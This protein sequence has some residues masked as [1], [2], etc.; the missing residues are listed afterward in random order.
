MS[1]VV[2]AL[3]QELVFRHYT[4]TVIHYIRPTRDLAFHI[5]Q[6]FI[7]VLRAISRRQSAILQYTSIKGKGMHH[8]QI[9][10]PRMAKLSTIRLG[11]L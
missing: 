10:L 5:P 3:D 9:T 2:R 11:R 4:A 7:V 1:L 6:A 8:N